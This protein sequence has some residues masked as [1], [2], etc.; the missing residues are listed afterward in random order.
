MMSGYNISFYKQNS[1]SNTSFRRKADSMTWMMSTTEHE[2]NTGDT[3][4]SFASESQE[5]NTMIIW[6]L[7]YICFNF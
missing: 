1:A 4:I 2:E 6:G 5:L 3:N 7:S